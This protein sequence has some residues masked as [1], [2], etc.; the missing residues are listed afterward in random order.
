MR[1]SKKLDNN[2]LWSYYRENGGKLQDPQEFLQNFYYVKTP[3]T[4]NGRVLAYNSDNRD[5]SNFLSDMDRKFE[6][7]I[8]LD[9]NGEFVKV[10]K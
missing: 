2:W 3:V 8:L 5:L 10:V 7:Q 6:L 4:I 1:N 9:V